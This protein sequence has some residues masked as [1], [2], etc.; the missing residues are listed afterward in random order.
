[1]RAYLPHVHAGAHPC[2]L[3]VN[4]GSTHVLVANYSSGTATALP[5]DPVCG[6]L[7]PATGGAVVSHAATAAAG[8]DAVAGN[9]GGAHAHSAVFCGAEDSVVYV[10]DL[11]L[12]HIFAH[13]FDSAA[14]TL[15]A[16]TAAQVT[17]GGGVLPGGECYYT[18]LPLPL[19]AS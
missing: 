8:G 19:T 6:A 9:R 4:P 5:I 15:G 10:P 14:G 12:D 1:M 13:P 3:S 7:Q 16:G 17:N 2:H 18:K 11:G